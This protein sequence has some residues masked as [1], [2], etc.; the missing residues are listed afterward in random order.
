MKL[1]YSRL[2]M[3]AAAMF[4]RGNTYMMKRSS[5]CGKKEYAK[6]NTSGMIVNSRIRRSTRKPKGTRRMEQPMARGIAEMKYH[7][8]G[9]VYVKTNAGLEK[10]I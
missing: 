3:A 9:E 5:L 10:L 7:E 6:T 4:S 2:Q 1:H 8:N